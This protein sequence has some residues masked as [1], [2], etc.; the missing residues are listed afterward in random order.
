MCVAGSRYVN[1]EQEEFP[2][3]VVAPYDLLQLSGANED[4]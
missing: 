3:S 2:K 4:G 1:E